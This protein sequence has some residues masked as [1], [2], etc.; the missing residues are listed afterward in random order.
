MNELDKQDRW[1]LA[2][3]VVAIVIVF[4]LSCTQ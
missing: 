4:V 1:M 3:A 2:M